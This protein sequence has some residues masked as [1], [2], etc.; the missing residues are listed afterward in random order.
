LVVLRI[1]SAIAEFSFD[2]RSALVGL[3]IGVGEVAIDIVRQEGVAN[4]YLAIA[5]DVLEEAEVVVA[6]SLVEVRVVVERALVVGIVA[7]ADVDI[8]NKNNNHKNFPTNVQSNLHHRSN[9]CN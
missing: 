4:V 3:H 1:D 9:F 6:A 5:P 8:L 2:F 7:G